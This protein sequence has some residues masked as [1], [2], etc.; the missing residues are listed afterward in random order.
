VRPSRGRP[1]VED[2]ATR[3]SLPEQAFPTCFLDLLELRRVSVNRL[4]NKIALLNCFSSRTIVKSE[5]AEIDV[6]RNRL[7]T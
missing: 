6:P 5:T 1:H 7:A 2:V 3:L 4:G